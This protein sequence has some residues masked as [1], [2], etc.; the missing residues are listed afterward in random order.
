MDLKKLIKRYGGKW[1][2][3]NK[4]SSKVIASSKS[5]KRVYDEAKRGGFKIP[6]LYKVPRKDLP[7]I[8]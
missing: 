1:V 3:L 5:A 8:G 7:Y 4:D 2:A 6:L